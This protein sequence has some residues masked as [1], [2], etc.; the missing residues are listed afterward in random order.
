MKDLRW[1]SGGSPEP[2]GSCSDDARPGRVPEIAPRAG[3]RMPRTR[4][5]VR[6]G[7]CFRA[8]PGGC[9]QGGPVCLDGR[10]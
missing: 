8:G 2:R 4:A 3:E 6:G 1:S 7:G 10:L 9:L 5:R